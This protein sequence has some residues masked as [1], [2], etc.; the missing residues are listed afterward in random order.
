MSGVRVKIVRAYL[1]FYKI[2]PKNITV[3][4]VWDGRRDDRKKPIN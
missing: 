1:I 3:L 2:S 4:S